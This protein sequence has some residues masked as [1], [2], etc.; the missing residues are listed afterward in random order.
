MSERQKTL[1]T[2]D[3]AAIVVVNIYRLFAISGEWNDNARRKIAKRTPE[4]SIER[5]ERPRTTEKDTERPERA[6][7]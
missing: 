6:T 3:H 5:E 7:V 1:H 2:Q 4:L